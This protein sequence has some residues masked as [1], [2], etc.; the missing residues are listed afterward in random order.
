M[1][2]ACLRYPSMQPP[3]IYFI[4]IG[5]PCIES[6]LVGCSYERATT[7]KKKITKICCM[8]Q[9]PGPGP[10]RWTTSFCIFLSAFNLN[11]NSFLLV[12]AIRYIHDACESGRCIRMKSKTGGLT[13]G[14]VQ[15]FDLV[16]MG[17]A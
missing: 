9:L 3:C 12:N 16:V 1:G 13:H 14:T 15:Q 4:F 17:L 8:L 10:Q 6:E 5:R 11:G 2:P 7:T